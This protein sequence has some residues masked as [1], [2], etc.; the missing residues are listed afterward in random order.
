MTSSDLQS[1]LQGYTTTQSFTSLENTV[2]G[3]GDDVEEL[4]TDVELLKLD[5][6][7]TVDGHSPNSSGAVSFG[8]T[9]SKWLKSDGNGHIVTTNDT[10]ITVS[11]SSS[12]Y[13]YNNSG[14]LEYKDDEYVTLDTQQ[15]ITATKYFTNNSSI[16]VNG[17]QI[18]VSDTSATGVGTTI[19]HANIF[20]N[21]GANTTYID[22]SYG[23][24]S[25]DGYITKSASGI[26][27]VDPVGVV[28]NAPVN[29]AKLTNH[30]TDTTTTSKAIATVGYCQEKFL[31]TPPSGYTPTTSNI[32]VVTGISWNGTQ[33]VATRTQ[34]RFYKGV[35]VGTTNQTNETINTV[36]Y[37][38]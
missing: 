29:G 27:I 16:N 4:S 9:A 7:K 25:N 11:P 12:G 23:N 20:L 10:P 5:W 14:T 31:A 22:M 8:L 33:I 18:T 17:G 13:L 38:P 34:L 28:L 21:G 35:F 19:D 1:T 37:T 6:I 26:S 3:L 32:T 24:T 30:P 15:T 2:D 36:A